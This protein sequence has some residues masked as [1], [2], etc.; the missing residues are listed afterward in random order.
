MP[1]ADLRKQTKRYSSVHL[2]IRHMLSEY[3][4]DNDLDFLDSAVISKYVK[5]LWI[6]LL[7]AFGIFVYLV[8]PS[9]ENN[10][11]WS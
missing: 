6:P 10:R 11:E 4:Q 5:I 8:C 9:G 2:H 3:F 7:L 1:Q